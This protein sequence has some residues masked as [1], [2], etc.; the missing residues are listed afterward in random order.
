[1]KMSIIRKALAVGFLIPIICILTGYFLIG[2]VLF[3]TIVLLLVFT[4]KKVT[5]EKTAPLLEKIKSKYKLDFVFFNFRKSKPKSIIG[6]FM[7]PILPFFVSIRYKNKKLLLEA[8]FHELA[9]IYYFVYWFQALLFLILIYGLSYFKVNFWLR[10]PCFVLFLVFQ[11]VLAFHKAHKMAKEFGI[12][13]KKLSFKMLLQYVFVYTLMI[14][15]LFFSLLEL[16]WIY[17][18]LFGKTWFIFSLISFVLFV[19]ILNIV[20][21]YF[22]KWLGRWEHAK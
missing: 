2:C 11:E 6:G 18:Q 22:F 4:N 12:D 15:G 9:H 13:T 8:I 1:M 20:C 3:S 10:V 14:G 5:M 21:W 19:K 16:G 7:I 17:Y